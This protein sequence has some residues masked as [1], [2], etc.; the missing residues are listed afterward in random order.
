MRLEIFFSS[1]IFL[2]KK[3]ETFGPLL[4]LTVKQKLLSNSL[5][6]EVIIFV[7]VWDGPLPPFPSKSRL[8]GV[9]IELLR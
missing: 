3:D 6:E 9:S 8:L 2:I 5:L 1:L 7:F 4:C